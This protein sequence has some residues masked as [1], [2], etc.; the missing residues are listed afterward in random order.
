MQLRFCNT[1]RMRSLRA[2]VSKRWY[3]KRRFHFPRETPSRSACNYLNLRIKNLNLLKCVSPGLWF[4]FPSALRLRTST[5]SMSSSVF[6]IFLYILFSSEKVTPRFTRNPPPT[7]LNAYEHDI[8]APQAHLHP[9]VGRYPG[10]QN[11]LSR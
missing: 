4:D 3:P 9:R 6:I 2:I 11:L 10:S 8:V 7:I 5:Q 1:F